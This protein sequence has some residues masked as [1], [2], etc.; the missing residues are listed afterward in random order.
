MKRCRGIAFA[1]LLAYATVLAPGCAGP[2][3]PVV[4]R[5]ESSSSMAQP[6]MM[7]LKS[8]P[9]PCIRILSIDGGGVR[10]ILPAMF[11]AAVEKRTGRPTA[12]LFDLIVGTSTGANLALALAKPDPQHPGKPAYSAE[13]LARFYETQGPR[14]FP[15]NY[16]ALRN[17]LWLFKPKYPAS[18]LESVL[19]EYFGDARL[20]S[21]LTRV[22]I[23]TYEIEERRRF[24]FKSWDPATAGFRMREVARAATA[25]PSY[26]PPVVLSADR[27]LDPKGYLALIDAA[28][29]ANSPELYAHEAAHE[30]HGA[31]SQPLIIV[32]LGTG[33]AVDPIPYDKAWRWGLL[34]WSKPLLDILFSAP[35]E[36]LKELMMYPLMDYPNTYVRLQPMLAAQ[37]DALDDAR[38][39]NIRA[40]KAAAEHYIAKN[41]GLKAL[42]DFLMKPRPPGC[43]ASIMGYRPAN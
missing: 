21:A 16:Q 27:S 26:F 2:P 23:P 43:P 22:E 42:A 20:G 37:N 36:N 14:I 30:I 25:A 15:T 34:F 33:A 38:P 19:K 1:V 11:L 5:A 6:G 39:E 4:P 17:V 40:L 10:G 32:S 8:P 13:G 12:E 29:F 24:F 18:G 31:E 9:D 7:F 28:V 35:A 41:D 3:P